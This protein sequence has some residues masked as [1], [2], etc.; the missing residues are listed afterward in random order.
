MGILQLPPLGLSLLKAGLTERG[1]PCDLR[2]LN[3]EFV[4]RFCPGSG[5]SAARGYAQ[6]TSRYPLM[7]L[8]EAAFSDVLFGQDPARDAI[9]QEHLAAAVPEDRRWLESMSKAVGPFIDWCVDAVDWRQYSVVGFATTFAGMT[10]PAMLLA[11]RIKERYTDLQIVVGGANTDGPMGIELLRR[12]PQID[13]VLRGECDETFPQLV[14]CLQDRSPV[15]DLPGLVVRVPET[16]EVASFPS[17]PVRDLS[18]LPYPDFDDF[19][20]TCMSSSYADRFRRNLEIAFE[21]SRGCWWGEV[22]HCRFCGI[23]ADSMG[24]RRKSPKRVREELDHLVERYHP[25]LLIAADSILDHRYYESFMPDLARRPLGVGLCY[26][27]KSN[28][29]RPQVQALAEAGVIEIRPGIET[30]STRLL[31][32]VNKGATTLDNLLCLRLAEEYGLGVTWYH[33]CG[34][35]SERVRDY[36][37]EIALIKLI[38]HLPPPREIARFTLQ[39]FSPYFE[40]ANEHGLA[41]VRSVQVYRSVYPFPDESLGELAYHFDFRFDDG[42]AARETSRIEEILEDAVRTWKAAYGRVRLDAV[43][44]DGGLLIVDTRFE[45]AVV[46]VLMGRGA[47]LYQSLDQPSTSTGLLRRMTADTA[48]QG[49]MVLDL[50]FDAENREDAVFE[51]ARHQAEQL[52]ATLVT[53]ESPLRSAVLGAEADRQVQ[54]ERFLAEMTS[55]GLIYTEGSRSIALAVFRPKEVAAATGAVPRSVTA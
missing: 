16:G 44:V 1:I 26:E 5:A 43:P 34:L 48:S 14:R 30:L 29:R 41:D 15:P 55:A 45:P 19:I 42:R 12:F 54:I 47:R 4:D 35:P 38:P 2:Y 7:F 40:R 50:V 10:V 31:D 27:I 46:F 52:G 25:H 8:A 39:R 28:L 17:I 20:E 3:M 51:A 36:E 49:K 37:R 9:V 6:V 13:Y 53:I 24:F 23:N 18:A 33:L 11:Q 22:R 32:L 21:S